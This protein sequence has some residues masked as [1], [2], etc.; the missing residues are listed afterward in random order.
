MTQTLQ[1]Q[2]L[3]QKRRESLSTG[4]QLPAPLLRLTSHI[5]LIFLE[6]GFFLGCKTDVY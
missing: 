3:L 1:R 4:N 5:Y 6:Y 2:N